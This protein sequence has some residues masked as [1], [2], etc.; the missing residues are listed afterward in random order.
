MCDHLVIVQ[1]SLKESGKPALD[2]SLTEESV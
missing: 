2:S 1:E